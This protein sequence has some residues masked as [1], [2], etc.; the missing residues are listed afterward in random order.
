MSARRRNTVLEK[1]RAEA[2]EIKARTA[3]ERFRFRKEQGLGPFYARILQGGAE[4]E[5]YSP[6]ALL[7]LQASRDT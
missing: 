1:T 4:A 2:A 7:L 5:Q 6:P 3:L